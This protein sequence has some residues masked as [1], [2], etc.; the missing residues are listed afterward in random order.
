MRSNTLSIILYKKWIFLQFFFYKILAKYSPKRTKLHKFW[1][2]LNH[3]K[4]MLST[5]RISPPPPP[6]PPLPPKKNKNKLSATRKNRTSYLEKKMSSSVEEVAMPILISNKN[7]SRVH[8][9]SCSHFLNTLR[10]T[11]ICVTSASH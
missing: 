4:K 1:H 11:V 6:P 3:S 5:R 8:F 10:V 7:Y 2:K 9:Y